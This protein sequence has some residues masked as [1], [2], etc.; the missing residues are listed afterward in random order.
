MTLNYEIK[1]YHKEWHELPP[2]KQ[3]EVLQHY[4]EHGV[5]LSE[6]ELREHIR[7]CIVEET[8]LLYEDGSTESY[9]VF[10]SRAI[11]NGTGQWIDHRWSDNQVRI[12]WPHH[13]WL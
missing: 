8:V 6:E 2:E 9:Y 3:Q 10:L 4:K 1:V 13:Y 5:P 11:A 7:T 12:N